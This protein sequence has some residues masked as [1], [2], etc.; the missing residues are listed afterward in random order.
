MKGRVT[1]ETGPSRSNFVGPESHGEQASCADISE[2][3]KTTWKL[4]R[5]GIGYC[6]RRVTGARGPSVSNVVGRE[7]RGEQARCA[8]VSERSKTTSKLGR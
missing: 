2:I 8:D 6:S 3:A 7:S 1:G 5:Q 4:G